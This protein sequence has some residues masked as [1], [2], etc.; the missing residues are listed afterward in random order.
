MEKL[1]V[2]YIAGDEFEAGYWDVFE[3]FEYSTK[4]KAE[5]DFFTKLLEA[6]RD[7]KMEFVFEGT[8]FP[9]HPFGEY[10]ILTLEEW[11]EEHKIN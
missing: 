8:C 10:K 4:D 9:T 6:E 11:F 3:P 7:K 1:V 5:E 2:K